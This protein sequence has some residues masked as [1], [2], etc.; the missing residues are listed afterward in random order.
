M[1]KHYIEESTIE[2]EGEFSLVLFND[3]CPMRCCYCKNIDAFEKMEEIDP[4]DKIENASKLTTAVVLLGGE[5]TCEKKIWEVASYAKELGYKVK[6]FTNGAFPNEIANLS[7][8]VDMVSIDFKGFSDIK[9][10]TGVDARIYFEN[11]FRTINILELYKVEWEVRLT[12]PEFMKDCEVDIISKFCLEQLGKQ[13]I[14]QDVK[15]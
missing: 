13:L 5:P 8:I 1:F 9:K 7:N 12:V 4:F 3:I 15:T 10:I 6:L 2:Y 14:I 11:L